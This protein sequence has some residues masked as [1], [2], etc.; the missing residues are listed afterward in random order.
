MNTLIFGTAKTFRS[1]T[2]SYSRS[3]A[4]KVAAASLLLSLAAAPAFAQ[5]ARRTR[6]ESHANRKA[7]I[8]RA[9][10][11]TYGH[12]Y[13]AGGGGGYLRFRSGPYLQ[14]NNEV[15]F[16]ASTMYALS[17]K[18]GVQGEVRGAYGKA[19]IGNT[20]FHIPNPQISDYSYLAGP[21]YRVVAKEKYSVSGFA[22]GGVGLAKFA[23]GSK[24]F[25]A[26]DIGVWTGDYAGA[27]SVGAHVDYNLYPNLAFRVTPF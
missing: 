8:E 15:T 22:E 5:S 1:T 27:F 3:T 16:W 9:I 25:T 26:Q 24:G 17:P 19:K 13:E 21:S 20:P 14:Q 12:K 10:A 7:R 2:R 23:G 11:Q 18:L 4:I 6:R